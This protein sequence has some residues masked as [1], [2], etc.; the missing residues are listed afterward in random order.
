MALVGTLWF[1][2]G[3]GI[4]VPPRVTQEI[5]RKV[6]QGDL[7]SVSALLIIP[8]NCRELP[9]RVLAFRALPDL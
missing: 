8:G 4:D 3:A 6:T 7:T 1:R 2:L 9:L 5:H